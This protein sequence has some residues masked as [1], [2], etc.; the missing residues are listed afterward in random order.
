M[1]TVLNPVFNDEIEKDLDAT[2]RRG[3]EHNMKQL[4]KQSLTPA[5]GRLLALMQE[6]NFGW[7]KG[8]LVVNGEPVFDPMP[9]VVR[10]VKFCSENGPRREKKLNDFKLK[11]QVVELFEAMDRMKNGVIETLEIK[12]GLPFLMNLEEAAG[13]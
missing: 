2:N 4:T 11:E 9:R 1:G 6:L 13:A 12:H 5:R 10:Q 3:K 8:L 7:I